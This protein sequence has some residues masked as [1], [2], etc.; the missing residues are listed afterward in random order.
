MGMRSKG[1]EQHPGLRVLALLAFVLL[2]GCATGRVPPGRRHYAQS[3][4]SAT[5]G[6]LRNPGCV[7]VTPGEEA[8]IPWLS[9]AVEA[10][11]IAATVMRL[12]DVAELARVEQVLVACSQEANLKINEREYGPGRQPDDNECR[13]VVG[14]ERGEKVTRA[15]E[16]G[17]TYKLDP[18]TGRWLMLDPKLVA[19]WVTAQLFDLLVGTLVPDIV[20][21]AAGN[22]NQIQRV[23]DLKFPCVA[24]RKSNPFSRRED[25]GVQEQLKNKYGTLGGDKEPALV[26]PQLGVQ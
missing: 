25:E 9:R 23:Y 18:T 2:A 11:R 17:P 22:P 12:L 8:T 15:I 21:H 3:M 7:V 13:R 5:D 26:T 6:C 24:K 19:K 1:T 16:L 10:A 14:Q 4:N 20:I